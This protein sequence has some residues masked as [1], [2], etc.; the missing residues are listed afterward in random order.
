[1]CFAKKDRYQLPSTLGKT[2]RFPS[3]QFSLAAASS[4]SRPPSPP[5]PGGNLFGRLQ[6]ENELDEGA[7]DEVQDSDSY[8]DEEEEEDF[9]NPQDILNDK[10]THWVCSVNIFKMR[11]SYYIY[12][13]MDTCKQEQ[14][15]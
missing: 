4:A 13:Q 14:A 7:E 11:L 1:M 9:D 6:N 12:I 10:I 8:E 5:P 2:S 15:H 3:S